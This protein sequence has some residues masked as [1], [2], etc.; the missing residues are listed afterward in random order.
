M[1]IHRQ[2]ASKPAQKVRREYAQRLRG[3][4]PVYLAAEVRPEQTTQT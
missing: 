4:V 1:N 3:A 2:S